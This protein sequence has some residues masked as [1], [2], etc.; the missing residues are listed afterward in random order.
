MRAKSVAI[1]DLAGNQPHCDD[2][3][4]RDVQFNP[5]ILNRKRRAILFEQIAFMRF[6]QR[7]TDVHC[8]VTPVPLILEQADDQARCHPRHT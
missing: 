1:S 7:K 4:R 5:V 3:V 2:L 6:S 8:K